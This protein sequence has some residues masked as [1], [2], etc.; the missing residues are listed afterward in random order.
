MGAFRWRRFVAVGICGITLMLVGC[1]GTSKGHSRAPGST[2]STGPRTTASSSTT[3][4]A[5]SL[6][7]IRCPH[8]LALPARGKYAG[9]VATVFIVNAGPK[10][11]GCGFVSGWMADWIKAGASPGGYAIGRLV[12]I[13]CDEPLLRNTGPLGEKFGR[14]GGVIHCDQIDNGAGGS[15]SSVGRRLSGYLGLLRPWDHHRVQSPSR[16]HRP[17]RQSQAAR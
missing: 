5:A 2:S 11:S 4:S 10:K 1:G 7:T 3:T 9:Q 13:R 16:A 17:D 15:P 8:R 6:K 14:Y 12:G